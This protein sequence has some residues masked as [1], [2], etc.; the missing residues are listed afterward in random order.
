[1]ARLA[2]KYDY[3]VDPFTEVD[4]ATTITAEG[5]TI[6]ASSP[7]YV[8]LDEVPRLDDP[9]TVEIYNVTDGV[10]MLEVSA[11]PASQEYQVDY[12]TPLGE[13]PSP[14]RYGTGKIRFNSA[15]AGKRVSVSYMGTGHL[16]KAQLFNDLNDL[17]RGIPNV[18]IS[19]SDSASGPTSTTYMNF[20]G[21]STSFHSY[22]GKVMINMSFL[23]KPTTLGS[24][25]IRAIVAGEFLSTQ[26]FSVTDGQTK[27]FC[28]VAQ[29]ASGVTVG[30]HDI[31]L[32]GASSGSSEHLTSNRRLMA[33][34]NLLD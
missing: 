1:M 12:P 33:F 14:A 24:L 8:Q 2:T 4:G 20:A 7:F 23:Y 15:Q 32:Q 22:G 11:S 19:D 26:T 10:T 9:S 29:T 6:P 13:N 17:T 34:C 28:Y 21:M 16:T 18:K 25:T 27:S 3:R 5:L 31:V 30:I